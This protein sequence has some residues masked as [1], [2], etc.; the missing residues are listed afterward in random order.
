PATTLPATAPWCR[1]GGAG[2]GLGT[3]AIALAAEEG[4]KLILEASNN[5]D[6]GT[7]FTTSAT[8]PA[9]A[10]GRGGTGGAGAAGGGAAGGAGGAPAAPRPWSINAPKFPAQ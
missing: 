7:I 6:G 10:G 8:V 1:R 3:R 4:A 9:G 2:A 5:G